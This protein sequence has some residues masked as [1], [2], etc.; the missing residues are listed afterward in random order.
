M[1]DWEL[2]QQFVSAIKLAEKLSGELI[3]IQAWNEP[4]DVFCID[5]DNDPDRIRIAAITARQ[6]QQCL[7]EKSCGLGFT[8][9]FACKLEEYSDKWREEVNAH[10]GNG[11]DDLT[12]QIG[13]WSCASKIT[14]DLRNEFL[15]PVIRSLATNDWAAMP[16]I[17]RHLQHI[18]KAMVVVKREL[19]TTWRI[20][21]ELQ[22][23]LFDAAA[24][25]N[26]PQKVHHLDNFDSWVEETVERRRVAEER[27]EQERSTFDASAGEPQKSGDGNLEAEQSREQ[28]EDGG[29][30]EEQEPNGEHTLVAPTADELFSLL[31][32]A[33]GTLRSH[34]K[35]V[36]MLLCRNNGYQKIEDIVDAVGSLKWDPPY[37]A[38]ADSLKRRINNK[39]SPKGFLIEQFDNGFRVRKIKKS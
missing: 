31:E 35:P 28:S 14:H 19:E 34:Q 7:E 5:T 20:R 36:V 2:Y 1:D 29:T 24:T 18:V 26:I 39:L 32:W 38:N 10:L 27:R 11:T 15:E 30:E 21:R 6:L 9:G 16:H 13:Y 22:S 8:S 17:W 4:D 25:A 37:Q 3:N 33:D 23:T 12:H